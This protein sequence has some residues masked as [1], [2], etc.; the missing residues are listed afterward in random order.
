[1]PDFSKTPITSDEDVNKWL[2]FY[3]MKAPL[4]A[5][6][7]LVTSEYVRMFLANL[8]WIICQATF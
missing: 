4:V 3:E 2:K 7:T 5:V 8:T 6:G 1:M